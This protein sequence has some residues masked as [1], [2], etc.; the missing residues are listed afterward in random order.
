MTDARP[1]ALVTGASSGIGFELA[2]LFVENGYDLVANAEDAGLERAAEE[3]RG[4][5]AT[6]Y[7]AQADLS[8]PNGVEQLYAAVAQ[9]GRPLSAAAL[10]AGIGHGG[11]FVDSDLADELRVIQVNV[12]STVHLAHRLLRDMVAQGDGRVLLTSSIAS[13][14]AGPFQAVYNASKSFLTSFGEALQNE[15]KDTAVTVT[16]LLPG[17]T[18]TEFFHRAEMD[19]TRM[20]QGKKDEPAQVAQQGFDAM[21][22]GKDK[23][24]GGSLKTKAMAAANTVTPDALKSE[25]HRHL[26]KPGSGVD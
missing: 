24:V 6:V 9:T 14:M 20:G 7:A 5:G 21:L 19:D 16:T 2:R 22:A 25:G 4:G 1:L 23:V 12:T 15:L 8:T 18:D 13:T 10:N 17:P 26:A 3:L 11:A